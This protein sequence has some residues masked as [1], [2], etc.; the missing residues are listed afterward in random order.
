MF[1]IESNNQ[2]T[3][4]DPIVIDVYTTDAEGYTLVGD[5]FLKGRV[6]NGIIH[7]MVMTREYTHV[8]KY[9]WNVVRM[10]SDEML[11]DI[12]DLQESVETLEDGVQVKENRIDILKDIES[13]HDLKVKDIEAQSVSVASAENIKIGSDDSGILTKDTI[14]EF[15]VDLLDEMHI[16]PI[17]VNSMTKEDYEAEHGEVP[18][19]TLY[20]QVT[21]NV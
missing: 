2:N 12:L 13:E 20:L 1:F 10:Y 15:I 9:T 21:E 16:R 18:N 19:G 6:E 3:S 7:A 14:R 17:I 4:E 8:T 11:Q 5:T